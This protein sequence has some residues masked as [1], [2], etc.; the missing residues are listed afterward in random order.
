MT[1]A[2]AVLGDSHTLPLLR[3]ILYG[4]RRFSEL[5]TLTGA[6]RSLLTSRLRRLEA[7]G[8]VTRRRYSERPPRDEYV[9]TEAGVDLV[10][11]LLALKVWGDRHTGGD[12]TPTAIFRH[13]C[14]AELHPV[15]VCGACGEEIRAGEFDV[16]G[17]THPPVLRP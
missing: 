12:A 17:G 15:S 11:V 2:V 10:P 6:P 3:E 8:V 4:Y 1:D 16:A 5:A 9:L 7:A 13:R 14:G